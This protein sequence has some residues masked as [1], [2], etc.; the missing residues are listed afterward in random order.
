[1]VKQGVV[2]IEAIRSG[3]I[4]TYIFDGTNWVAGA[5]GTGENG[6][7]KNNIVIGDDARAENWG[8][9]IGGST[10]ADIRGVAVGKSASGYNYGVAVGE[11]AQGYTYGVAIGNYA[12]GV[13]YGVALGYNADT[14][15]KKGAVA[16]GYY[17]ETEREAE[18]AHN[19]NGADTDQENNITIGGWEGSTANATPA[20][21]FCGGESNKRFTVRASSVLVFTMLIT[22]RDNVAGHGAAYKVE[23]A[24]KRDAA[25]NTAMLAAATVTVI[26]ED[27]ASWDVAVTADDTNEALII[28]VTGDDTNITQWAARLDGVETHF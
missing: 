13:N 6:N 8:T 18:I 20:E 27:D 9:A 11:T 5:V 10:R 1:M 4:K 2:E 17:A 23:G 7:I 14:N 12:D 19:I 28:T 3:A 26:H 15:Q 16:L 21:I 22:A 24:I 25:G